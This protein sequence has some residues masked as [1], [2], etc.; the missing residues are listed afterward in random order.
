[1]GGRGA[2][3][4]LR[5]AHNNNLDTLYSPNHITSGGMNIRLCGISTKQPVGCAPGVAYLH[6]HDPCRSGLDYL[7]VGMAFGSTM[8]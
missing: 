6:R 4:L 5:F 1:M 3:D 8:G 7:W 2:D